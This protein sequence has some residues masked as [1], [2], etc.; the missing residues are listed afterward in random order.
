[1]RWP[2]SPPGFVVWA[3]TLLLPSFAKSGWLPDGFI[4]HGLFGIELLRPQQLFGLTGLDEITHCLVWSLLANLGAYVGVSLLR[5]PNAREARQATLFVGAF[6]E[7]ATVPGWRGSAGVAD[8]LPLLAAS[9]AARVPRKAFGAM[10]A[11][12]GL[13]LASRNCRPT[14]A[15]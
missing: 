5:V 8:L 2:G 1:V 14:R 9:S 7:A 6:T 11:S 4:A 12:R 3:Y 10:R 15:W 13:K